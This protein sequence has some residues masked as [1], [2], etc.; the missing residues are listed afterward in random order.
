MLTVSFA[1]YLMLV[2]DHLTPL[3]KILCVA[4]CHYSSACAII[5]FNEKHGHS[6]DWHFPFVKIAAHKSFFPKI[7]FS[8]KESFTIVSGL[9][10]NSVFIHN[11]WNRNIKC[12]N[13]VTNGYSPIWTDLKKCV[14]NSRKTFKADKSSNER[15]IEV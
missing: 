7:S 5:Q 13:I 2:S 4:L 10:T 1:I 8:E 14:A 12:L 6:F 15:R 9:C 11:N 3:L